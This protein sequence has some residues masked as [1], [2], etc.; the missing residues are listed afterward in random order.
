MRAHVGGGCDYEQDHAVTHTVQSLVRVRNPNDRL[1]LARA[2]LLGLRDRRCRAA[3]AA[4]SSSD[5]DGDDNIRAAFNAQIAQQFRHGPEARH[6]LRRA[7]IALDKQLYNLED[8]RML[9]QWIDQHHGVGA[10]RL[11]VFAKDHQYRIVFKG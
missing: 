2:V 3:A 11:V 6:L 8:V 4:A 10:V 7:G 5:N 1:C 9:Q